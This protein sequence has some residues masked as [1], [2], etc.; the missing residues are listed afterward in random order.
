MHYTIILLT[1]GAMS[2]RVW[3][4]PCRW[5]MHLLAFVRTYVTSHK[6]TT[7]RVDHV[8]CMQV[9]SFLLYLKEQHRHK[10]CPHLIIMPASLVTNWCAGHVLDVGSGKPCQARTHT[11]HAHVTVVACGVCRQDE[12]QRFAP[13]LQVVTYRGNAAVRQSVWTKV[14]IP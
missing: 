7:R 9:L 5:K 12:M 8:A 14:R 4:R 6:H 10:G 13:S 11:G 1:R 2:C 3:G